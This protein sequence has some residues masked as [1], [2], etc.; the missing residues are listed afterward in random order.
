MRDFLDYT[1]MFIIECFCLWRVVF[2][3]NVNQFGLVIVVKC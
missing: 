2:K 3:L 1:D